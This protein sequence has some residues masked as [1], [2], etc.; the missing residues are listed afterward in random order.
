MRRLTQNVRHYTRAAHAEV[1]GCIADPN[2]RAVTRLRY[3]NNDKE[4]AGMVPWQ[5]GDSLAREEPQNEEL[6][7]PIKRNHLLQAS[8]TACDGSD[9][10]EL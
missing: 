2:S 9:G 1:I 6:L 5:A 10:Q 3:N 4:E 8:E 7:H